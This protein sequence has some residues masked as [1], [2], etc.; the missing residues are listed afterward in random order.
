MLN[1]FAQASALL[2]TEIH[3]QCL[4]MQALFTMSLRYRLQQRVKS[5]IVA[6][7]SAQKFLTKEQRTVSQLADRI[8][9][10]LSTPQQNA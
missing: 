9:L 7:N 10:I 8:T 5:T 6:K 4:P 1:V 3:K 2:L